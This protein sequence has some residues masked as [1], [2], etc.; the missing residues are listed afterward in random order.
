MEDKSKGWVVVNYNHPTT[1]NQY[2]LPTTFKHTRKEAIT[3]FL[4]GSG[5]PWRYWRDKYNFRCVKAISV[6]S[7]ILN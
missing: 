4:K 1:G 2:I 3:E 6:I 5:S 7:V